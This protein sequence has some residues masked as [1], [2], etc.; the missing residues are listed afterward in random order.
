MNGSKVRSSADIWAFFVCSLLLGAVIGAMLAFS[1][2]AAACQ[3]SDGWLLENARGA[4][5][6]IALN[7]DMTYE[8]ARHKA[9]RIYWDTDP[10]CDK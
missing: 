7:H 10:G 8:Q 9:N 1:H 4:L 3:P 2:R 5:A 6:D